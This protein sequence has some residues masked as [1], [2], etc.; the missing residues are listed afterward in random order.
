MSRNHTTKSK[1]N[2]L[3]FSYS[4]SEFVAFCAGRRHLA[5]AL[6]HEVLLE[7]PTAVTFCFS[8]DNHT[9]GVARP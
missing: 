5:Q 6:Q 1:S 9:N 4:L 2:V 7:V 8:T 3:N